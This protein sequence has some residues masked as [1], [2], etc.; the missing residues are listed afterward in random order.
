MD[1]ETET[2]LLLTGRA[3]RFATDHPYAA[4]GIFWC[5]VGS[6][7]TYKVIMFTQG[8][9]LSDI[10]TPKVYKIALSHEGLQH[11]LHDPDAELR[12]DT[13]EVSVIITSEKV[14]PLKELP[15]ID[16]EHETQ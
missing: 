3:L 12:W 4:T 9:P 15:I 16:I 10:L 8:R 5:A 1:Q 13:P 7:V 11:L 14:E 6:A 2:L